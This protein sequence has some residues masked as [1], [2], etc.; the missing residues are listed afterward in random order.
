MSNMKSVLCCLVLGMVPAL[1]Q[2]APVAVYTKFQQQPPPGVLAA[3]KDETS[4][5]LARLGVQ[6]E[7]RSMDRVQPNEVWVEVAVV[8]FKGACDDAVAIPTAFQS[9]SL[10]W[11]HISDGEV[12]P[13]AEVDC[14]LVRSFLAPQLTAM[15]RKDSHRRYARALGRVVAHE[16]YHILGRSQHHSLHGVDQP[17]YRAQDLLSDRFLLDES[18]YRI[19]NSRADTDQTG[20]APENGS[21]LFRKRGC[22]AC[23]GARAEGTRNGPAL[24]AVGRFM[25]SVALAARLGIGATAM[26]RKAGRL[27]VPPP[28][29]G[30]AE[31]DMLVRFLNTGN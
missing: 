31:I 24:R 1:G 4:A 7:W 2:I 19:L 22:T 29:V 6:V 3:L 27:K 18:S 28:S 26:F 13:F 10:G 30:E 14:G 20:E 11:T 12:L 25:S 23:H 15:A 9:R 5:I 16:L 8:T 17:A 21:S